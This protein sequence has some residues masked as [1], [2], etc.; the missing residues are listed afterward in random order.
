MLFNSYTFWIFFAVVALVYRF[1]DHRGRNHFLL[2]SSYVFYGYW[3]W[4]FLTLIAFSTVVDFVAGRRIARSQASGS[5]GREWLLASLI[6]NLGLLAVF[7]YFGFFV[8][9]F[10]TLLAAFGWEK[11]LPGVELILPV[12]IS[13]YTFQTLS[14]TID[15]YQGKTRPAQ[16]PIDF[17]VYV[18]FFPQLVA[19]PIE[20]SSHL[21]PQVVEPR[22]KLDEARFREGLYLV[23]GGLFRKVVI[24]DNMAMIAN[25]IFSRPTEQLSGA[26]VLIG[27]YAF[28]FQIYGDFS[29]YS[30]IAQGTAKW[31]G[32]DLMDNF[33]HPYFARSPREFWQRWHISLSTWL[34]DYLYIP[35]GGNRKGSWFTYRNLMITMVL[36]GLWHGAAWTFVIWGAIHGIWLALHRGLGGAR[37]GSRQENRMVDG[38]KIVVTF[39]LVCLTWLFFRAE[40]LEQALGM[41]EVLFA[42]P[43]VWNE[44]L[45]GFLVLM[46]FFL[47][48]LLVFEIW[49]ERRENL[50]S[51]NE[52]GWVSRGAVYLFIL[53]MLLFFG[54]PERQE[55]IYFR[56]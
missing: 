2:L 5:L 43:W 15:V 26:E 13:F 24:A 56:F 54:A 37:G 29:G 20:R 35:L 28:A 19:G 10:N 52:L 7:K 22:P 18:S 32:F 39:H 12:G 17:A 31:L 34:R 1:L 48:P 25:Q 14:Y 3:D 55:F 41:L 16:N 49:L 9:E 33:R 11:G 36:G 45:T 30:S 38:I 47:I 51:L 27:V 8:S 50:Y 46:G 44:A 4:R 23:M 53:L 21:L 6:A 40:N 42:G